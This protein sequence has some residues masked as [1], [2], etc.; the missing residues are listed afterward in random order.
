[1]TVHC[2]HAKISQVA[3]MV[4]SVLGNDSLCPFL[5][6][7]STFKGQ[8]A[9]VS[10]TTCIGKYVGGLGDQTGYLHGKM[11][12]NLGEFDAATGQMPTLL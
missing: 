3:D 8:E 2:R 6:V 7:I 9:V 11:L 5:T 12:G 1:M 4:H 10:V